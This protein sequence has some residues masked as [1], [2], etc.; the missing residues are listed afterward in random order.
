MNLLQLL[1][2]IEKWKQEKEKYIYIKVNVK[3]IIVR[4]RIYIVS[5]TSSSH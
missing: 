2:M 4:K 3:S 5:V 1:R